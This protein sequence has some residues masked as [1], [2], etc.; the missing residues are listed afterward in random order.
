MKA[1]KKFSAAMGP[2]TMSSIPESELLS[3]ITL[4]GAMRE[5]GKKSVLVRQTFE[6]LVQLGFDLASKDYVLIDPLN[7]AALEDYRRWFRSE[8]EAS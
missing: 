2:S 4:L 6:G 3:S 7:E 8:E 1:L 5:D